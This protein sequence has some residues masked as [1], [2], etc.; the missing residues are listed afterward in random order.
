MLSVLDSI[1]AEQDNT[2]VEEVLA[3]WP[4]D[5][6]MNTEPVVDDEMSVTQQKK[7][8]FDEVTLDFMRSSST[9]P[10]WTPTVSEEDDCLDSLT[11]L[12]IRIAHKVI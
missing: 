10:E 4:L 2:E 12:V 6:E 1:L 9:K 3:N 11:S 8:E 5:D 7:I